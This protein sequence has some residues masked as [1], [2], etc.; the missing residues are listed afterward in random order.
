MRRLRVVLDM[1]V[2]ELSAGEALRY[3]RLGMDILKVGR[4]RLG[5][6]DS[7]VEGY[8]IAATR[9]GLIDGMRS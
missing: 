8:C 4:W 2:D 1:E 9:D 6:D 5:W 7:A 3:W